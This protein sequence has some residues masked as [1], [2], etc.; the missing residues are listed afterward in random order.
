[1]Q[2]LKDLTYII[3]KESKTATYKFA[4]IR[5]VIESIHKYDHYC[6]DVKEDN[7]KQLPI[8]L[9]VIFWIKYYYP[10]LAYKKQIPQITGNKNSLS[11]QKHLLPIIS[12]YEE[13]LGFPEFYKDL[14]NNRIPDTLKEDVIKLIRDINTTIINN[15]MKYIGSAIDKKGEIFKYQNDRKTTSLK[16]DLSIINIVES[17]GTYTIPKSYYSAFTLLGSYING[18]NALLFQWIDFS[19]RQQINKNISKSEIYQVLQTKDEYSR[20]TKDIKKIYTDLKR[21]E[22]LKCA[23]SNKTIKDDMHIDHIIPYSLWGNNDFWNLLPTKQ[24]YNS[25]KTD[26]IPSPNLLLLRK[27]IIID[28]WSKVFNIAP[29]RFTNEAIIALCRNHNP[30]NDKFLDLC[31][32]S[33]K[34]KCQFLIDTQGYVGWEP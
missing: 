18:D 2:T 17:C 26:K 31:F 34:N 15:P 28:Y 7:T 3:N 32:L 5:S 23:W 12:H 16:K 27:K 22:E 19:Y 11:F 24:K 29:N 20:D 30:N 33:L 8:G 10:I 25:S 6:T 21:K 13:S 9:L 1:M 14:Q 4:L